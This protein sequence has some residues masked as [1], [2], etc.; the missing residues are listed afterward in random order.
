MDLEIRYAR[1]GDHPGIADILDAAFGGT[2][3]R[4]IVERLR[5]AAPG[6]AIEAEE[7][8]R[9]AAAPGLRAAKARRSSERLS[10]T[11]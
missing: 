4:R 3:E 7:E 11:S 2:A 8:T 1:S 9:D 6:T 5:A 10:I